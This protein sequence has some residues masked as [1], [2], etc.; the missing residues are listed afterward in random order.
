MP[1]IKIK[2]SS[3]VTATA[4]VTNTHTATAPI[5]MEMSPTPVLTPTSVNPGPTQGVPTEVP[6]KSNFSIPKNLFSGFADVLRVE[7]LKLAQNV[8][9]EFGI[10]Y[11]DLVSKCLPEM[12]HIQLTETT[13]T[14][15]VK[16]ATKPKKAKKAVITNY[17]E[18]Q[19]LDDLKC[20]K[21]GDLKT[22]LEENDLAI[23]GSKTTLMARV[24]G[25]LHPDQAPDEPKKKRG[26]PAKAKSPSTVDTA[27]L[28]NTDV[29]ELDAEKMADF[30]VGENDSICEA[31]SDS[32]TT[33]KL[34]KTKY[35][36][37]EG[38]EEMEFK[39]CVEDGKI[40][41]TEDIPDDLLKM[42]GMED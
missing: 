16:S 22:I 3:T 1:T 42:L 8:A 13:E 30:F 39:G 26:R 31:A 19:S 37:Q 6:V 12:P 38:T 33:Y 24:W 23:S 27:P 7:Q 25:I 36:F 14:K 20:F 10:S 18:A 4:P 35:I 32:T 2:S 17:E 29:C 21:M 15:P 11:E 41:W 28:E 40:T 9:T 5:A 34:L